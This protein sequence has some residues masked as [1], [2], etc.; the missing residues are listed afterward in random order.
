M[1]KKFTPPIKYTDRDFQ[2]IKNSLIEY[3]K[4]YYPNTVNDFNEA[5][6]GSLML[7]S[8]A[9]IGDV[10]SFYLDYQTSESFLDSAIEFKNVLRLAQ[11]MGYKYSPEVTAYGTVAVYIKI[12]AESSGVSPDSRY[13]PTVTRGTRFGS[14]DN[15]PFI[16]L[17]DLTFESSNSQIVVSDVDSATGN[18]LY[19]ALKSYV[20]VISGDIGITTQKVEGYTPYKKITLDA[21]NISEILS[22]IDS[23]GNE[24]YEVEYLSQDTIY[25]SIPN[26]TADKALVTEIFKTVSVP[27]RFVVERDEDNVYLQFGGGN[28]SDALVQNDIKLDPRNVALKMHAKNYVSD[29]SFD[30]NI[31]VKN[32]NLG[33]APSD[34]TLTIIYRT[35]LTDT[36]N[37]GVGSL[38]SI[39][40]SE[41]VFE[42]E[43]VLSALETNKVRESLEVFNEEIIVGSTNIPTAQEIKVRAKDTFS[44]QNRAV[45]RQ[46][47][48]SLVYSMPGQFGKVTRCA[49]LQ[50]K[51]SFKR[52]MNLYVVSEGLDGTLLSTS[53]TIKQNLKNWLN[54]YK[55]VNDTIDIMDALVLNLAIDYTVIPEDGF[56]PYSLQQSII[57]ALAKAYQNPP[58]IGENFS[59][60]SVY[61]II[62]EV[63]GVADVQDV[64]ILN[65]SGGLYSEFTYDLDL[66][67][68]PDGRFIGMPLNVIYE[69]KFIENDVQG[70]IL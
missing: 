19:Y 49:L 70:T 61:N 14:V 16:T 20:P 36:I 65:K 9:Y 43:E 33:V 3:A 63:R 41:V 59:I 38:T 60:T 28:N 21:P 10:L 1:V 30:P 27:R 55:M 32:N 8:V 53:R 6:F 44:S 18:P 26:K 25:T 37:I 13:M 66:N 68:S 40:T 62:N 23:A 51:D 56:N 58:A 34:T 45:T 22:V 24:Y 50:D 7:D 4:R 17:E 47:Y 46:D 39:L 12:P 11:Q 31:L 5:S 15:I 42:N 52:N 35:N 48:M 54:R 57:A 64:D 2:S 67:T 29:A 69:I